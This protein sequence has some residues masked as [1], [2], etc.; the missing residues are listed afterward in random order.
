MPQLSS[1][2]FQ[3]KKD[4]ARTEAERLFLGFTAGDQAYAVA[5]EAVREILRVPK[6]FTL[7]RVPAFVKGVFDLRGVIVPALD[8]KE[9]LGL[10]A[11]EPKRG[12][13]IVVVP[14][15]KP[16]GVLVD[17]VVEVFRTVQEEILPPPEMLD[18]AQIGFINGMVR[19]RDHLY[20]LLDPKTVLT[21]KEF[22]TLETRSWTP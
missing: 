21:P 9:R 7:P 20:L 4:R 11:V 14:G 8:L 2:L 16:L 18:S 6:I 3:L 13:I 19:T 5:V 12:R 15:N 1:S 17:T 10:G 22:R